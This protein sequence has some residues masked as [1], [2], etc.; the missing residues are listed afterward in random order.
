MSSRKNGQRQET[1]YNPYS[2]MK[3]PSSSSSLSSSSQ[4]YSNN[5]YDSKISHSSQQKSPYSYNSYSSS[6]QSLSG[7][8][9]QSPYA[10]ATAAK[11]AQSP[12]DRTP[13]NSSQ[14]SSD[15]ASSNPYG[16]S[17]SVKDYSSSSSGQVNPY[18]SRS[19]Y[20]AP[21]SVSQSSTGNVT[22]SAPSSSSSNK[23]SG[24]SSG[25]A[26]RS[27]YVTQKNPGSLPSSASQNK[28]PP[29]T[30]GASFSSNGRAPKT[31]ATS[32]ESSVSG[33]T[34]KGPPMI[35]LRKARS[36]RN[37]RGQPSENIAP[38]PDIPTQ[39]VH[40]DGAK[41]VPSGPRPADSLRLPTSQK[42]QPIIN[43]PPMPSRSDRSEQQLNTL[44]SR[45]ET[46]ETAAPVSP[47]AASYHS[48][49]SLNGQFS[50]VQSNGSRSDDR[51]PERNPYAGAAVFSSKAQPSTSLAP[52]P[53]DTND[54]LKFVARDW[55]ELM[56]EDCNAVAIALDLMDTSSVGRSSDLPDFMDLSSRLEMIMRDIS[57]ERYADINKSI[58]AFKEVVASIEE[59]ETRV[60]TLRETLIRAKQN[61]TTKQTQMR[62]LVERAYRYREMLEILEQI[63][64]L[65]QIADQLE[66]NI[67][68]KQ[69]RA[70][71]ELLQDGLKMGGA[72]DLDQIVAVQSLRQYLKTQEK[73]L[74]NVMD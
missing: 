33:S 44:Q 65:R 56:S 35:P 43:V 60:R 34:E 72:Y 54:V 15:S 59:S 31:S 61:S 58:S 73:A 28:F 55:G 26:V 41:R 7:G 36:V 24:A 70:A 49:E 16:V 62:G 48:Q 29:P 69:Y 6:Q 74:S 32:G 67:A 42:S 20:S 22:S 27:P 25:Y 11:Q 8:S 45:T 38:V 68:D 5:P 1:A 12:F 17:S 19:L 64:K 9:N 10:S 66:K 14:R 57:E 2:G 13:T 71:Y 21:K 23:I 4:N 50:K 52:G 18:E 53:Q 40:K 46:R 3:P 39:R 47:Y 30:A 63:E 51:Q 37:M